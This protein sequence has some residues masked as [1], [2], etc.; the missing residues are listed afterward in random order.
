MRNARIDALKAN[1]R[2]RLAPADRRDQILS[3]AIDFFSE[4]GFEGTTRDLADKIGVKQPL[5]YRYFNSKEDLI[6]EVY[7]AT[8]AYRFREE[9]R[10]PLDDSTLSVNERITG[11]YRKFLA[12]MFK[13]TA[14]RILLYYGLARL[15]S[16]SQFVQFVE[17]EVFREL[18]SQLRAHFNQPSI[19][20]VQVKRE[21]IDILWLYH[22]GICFQGIRAEVFSDGDTMTGIDAFIETSV[23]GLV[24]S[25]AIQCK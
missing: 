13:P 24:R 9:W 14:T 21:E 17:T 20:A 18:A 19:E 16:S 8:C 3:E 15:N 22:G 7:A 6:R 10:T 25:F 1:G 5:I 4:V 12:T 11:F 2:Q 23:D